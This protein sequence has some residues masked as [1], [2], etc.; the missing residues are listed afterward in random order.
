[1]VFAAVPLPLIWSR[2]RKAMLRTFFALKALPPSNSYHSLLA[3]VQTAAVAVSLP[4]TIRSIP[5]RTMRPAGIAVA[6][7]D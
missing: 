4:V 3:T 2:L 6:T 7:W 1:M 5:F